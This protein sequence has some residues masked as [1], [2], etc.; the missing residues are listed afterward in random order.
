M[1]LGHYVAKVGNDLSSSSSTN[2]NAG[3]GYTGRIVSDKQRAAA[4]ERA[5]KLQR[6]L[7]SHHHSFVK[8]MVRS[9]VSGG[10][11]LVS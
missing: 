1:M 2:Q 5:E 11:W 7:E 9:H 8:P 10:F 6:D 4:I 3:R